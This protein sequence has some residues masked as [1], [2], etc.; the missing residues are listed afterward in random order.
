MTRLL[1]QW[2]QKMPFRRQLGIAVALGVLSTALFSAI[3]SSWQGSRQ[4]RQ[5]LVNQGERIAE[6]LARQ[7]RLALLVDSEENAAGAVNMTLAFPDVIRVE[8]NHLNG[9][10]LVA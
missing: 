5:T 3:G 8:I 10:S 7:S 1:P 6:N 4:I 9:K 2:F